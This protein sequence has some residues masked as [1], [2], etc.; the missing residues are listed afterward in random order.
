MAKAKPSSPRKP[1]RPAKPDQRERTP[2]HTPAVDDV[3][4]GTVEGEIE[5]DTER[6]ELPVSRT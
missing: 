5:F 3:S 6:Y 4:D 2:T 1:R